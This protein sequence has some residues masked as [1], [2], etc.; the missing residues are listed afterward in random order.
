MLPKSLSLSPSIGLPFLTQFVTSLS[1]I[2]HSPTHTA[3]K[4]IQTCIIELA[5]I[6]QD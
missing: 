1:K 5:L 3:N 2:T 4:K 6:K